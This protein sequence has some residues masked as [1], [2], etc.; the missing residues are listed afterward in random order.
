[1]MPVAELIDNHVERLTPCFELTAAHIMRELVVVNK[2]VSN[3]VTPSERIR[4][5]LVTVV[6]FATAILNEMI[7]AYAIVSDNQTAV[8]TAMS[9]DHFVLDNALGKGST[10]A[11]NCEEG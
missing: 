6:G 1:M 8:A 7:H 3:N 11:D 10:F 9:Q 5:F 4:K 2:V